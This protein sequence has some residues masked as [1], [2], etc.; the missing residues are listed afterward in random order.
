MTIIWW[1]LGLLVAVAQAVLT[2]LPTEIHTSELLLDAAEAPQ[3]RTATITT[4]PT[5]LTIT[6]DWDET[7][8]VVVPLADKHRLYNALVQLRTQEPNSA[9]RLRLNAHKDLPFPE[10]AAIMNSAGCFRAR[11]TFDTLAAFEASPFRAGEGTEECADLFGQV[12][13]SVRP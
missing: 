1:F 2:P 11:D 7:F 5:D 3:V 6:A 9:A 10:V 4:S 12:Q 13:L 8:R